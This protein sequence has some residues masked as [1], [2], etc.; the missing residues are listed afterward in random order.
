M[1][2]KDLGVVTAYAYAVLGGY[3]G[4]EEEFTELLGNIAT[5]LEEIENLSVTATTLPEGSSATASYSDGVLTLGIPRGNTGA[6]G[7]GISS[8]VL[9]ADYTLT[10]NYTNGQHVT[11]TSIRGA[12]GDTGN[13]I[14]SIYKTA[15]SGAVKTYT[16][17]YTNGDTFDFDVTDGE[18]T[19]ASLAATLE[20]YAKTD[21]YY[22]DMTVGDAEQL[23]S[24]I[25]EE[26]NTPYLFR[27]SGGSIDIGD[28]EYINGI[29]GVSVAWNQLVQNGNFVDTSNWNGGKF[30]LTVSNNEG[31]F[32][33][34]NGSAPYK[35]NAFDLL[36]G[37]KYF[38]TL[39]AKTPNGI[40]VRIYYNNGNNIVFINPTSSYATYAGVISN[41]TAGQGRIRVYAD[42]CQIG[43]SLTMKNAQLVDLTLALGNTI[44]DY[45]Y[46]LEQGTAGA[47][48]AYFR[49]LFTKP[50][51][52]YD[53]GSLK[54]VSGLKSHDMVGFNAWDEEWEVGGYNPSTGEKTTL[55]TRIR[56]KNSIKIIP[57][58]PYSVTISSA[59]RFVFFDGSGAVISDEIVTPSSGFGTFATPSTACS[60][61]FYTANDTY[62]NTYKNDICIN[63][64]WDGERDGEYEQYV[65]HSYALDDSVTLRGKFKL[66]ANNK[67]YADG[68]V[69]PPSGEG[70]TYY[71][72]VDLGEL[73]WNYESDNQRFNSSGIESL[74]DKSGSDSWLSN[75]VCSKYAVA[76]SGGTDKTIGVFR[77]TGRIYAFDSAYTDKDTFKASLAGV[78][79]LY[80]LA[81]PTTFTADP[82]DNPQVVDDF[83]TEEYV[84]DS[85]VT[86]P[87]PV[88]HNTKYTPNLRAKLEMLP[89]SP[90]SDGDYIVRHTSGESAF[91]LLEKELPSVPSEDG[92]YVLKCTVSSGTAALTWES[93]E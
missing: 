8:V 27:T 11:T 1:I 7:N 54:S 75:L 69:Y 58:T 44:A 79:L 22:Q 50:F 45:I 12:K 6:T 91:V 38:Y 66:D 57:S 16:I 62:G 90:D 88:G 65:K 47:G 80:P 81:T 3:T 36:A 84:I 37:H 17:L 76:S 89:S 43:D 93:E 34:N 85:S 86:V 74:V 39:S 52:A 28:R 83:G 25:Y 10:I 68:D 70:T 53:A 60:M 31:T 4:T 24:T 59:I 51:Y 13:G 87:I 55:A 49:K 18:V 46:S 14:A 40:G 41:T 20:D 26:D 42:S 63:L 29:V 78:K 15:E 2:T 82:Y 30:D 21:G 67:L 32:T 56:S 48:V 5:D 71:A 35:D 23:V 19:N 64:H 33:A 72:E 77:S 9:N 73:D 61:V 92:T